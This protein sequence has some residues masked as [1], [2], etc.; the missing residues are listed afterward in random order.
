MRVDKYFRYDDIFGLETDKDTKVRL[1]FAPDFR[2][3][4][5]G[6][7]DRQKLWI[8]KALL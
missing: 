4:D 7:T 8:L 6:E 3:E 1:Q 2:S 5:V